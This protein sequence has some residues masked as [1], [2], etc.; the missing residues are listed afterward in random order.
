MSNT[1]A[2]G[3]LR[4]DSMM[5]SSASLPCSAVV[6]SWPKRLIIRDMSFRVSASSSTTRVDKGVV[7]SFC[8]GG[9]GGSVVDRT[10]LSRRTRATVGGKGGKGGDDCCGVKSRL[11]FH[12][13]EVVGPRSGAELR[14]RPRRISSPEMVRNLKLASD[15]LAG[16][17]FGGGIA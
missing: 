1:A 10:A 15:G 3:V 4:W 8:D 6:T 5:R 12:P 7:E 14:R 11:V 13:N 17:V 16:V 2:P 9:G